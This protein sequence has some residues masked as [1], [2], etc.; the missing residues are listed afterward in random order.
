L[1]FLAATE[2]DGS[3]RPKDKKSRSYAVIISLETFCELDYVED[4]LLQITPMGWDIKFAVKV[5]R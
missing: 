4:A 5:R 1:R 3:T 2:V